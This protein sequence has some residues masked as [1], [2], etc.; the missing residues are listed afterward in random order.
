MET[1]FDMAEQA[2]A[3][4][5]GYAIRHNWVLGASEAGLTASVLGI[6]SICNMGPEGTEL[7]SP[8][9]YL[10]VDTVLPRYKVVALTTIQATRTFPST[11][12]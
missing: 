5:D 2:C 9:E 1:L 4:M 11:R 8:S 6:L 10:S 7:H 12:V 3:T